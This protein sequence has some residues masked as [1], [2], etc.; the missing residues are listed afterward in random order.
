MTFVSKK[1]A[2]NS[3]LTQGVKRS[4]SARLQGGNI[5]RRGFNFLKR[6]VGKVLK[7]AARI[8]P[9]AIDTLV[10]EGTKRGNIP[11][12]H[13]EFY[14]NFLQRYV[15]RIP[16][17]AG[18]HIDKLQERLNRGQLPISKEQTKEDDVASIILPVLEDKAVKELNKITKSTKSKG[19]KL[20]IITSGTG[21]GKVSKNKK[22]VVKETKKIPEL[23][24]ASHNELLR[25]FIKG[26]GILSQNLTPT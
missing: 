5:F 18:K 2:Y 26:S 6:N 12:K 15:E 17:L 4:P 7:T 20:K 10:S 14:N 3:W 1:K 25:S 21:P 9:K 19:G 11:K 8:L 24:S 23:G 22:K 16:Q 13:G